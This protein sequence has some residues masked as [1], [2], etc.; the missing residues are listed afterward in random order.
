MP[1]PLVWAD[2]RSTSP[3]QRRA[4]AGLITRDLSRTPA[5]LIGR[6][7]SRSMRPWRNSQLCAAFADRS[8]APRVLSVAMLERTAIAAMLCTGCVVFP[9]SLEPPPN[10][11]TTVVLLTGTLDVPLD[12]VARHPWF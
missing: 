11:L 4:R 6:P 2:Q 1:T 7:G 10:D 5:H 8:A 9:H 12:D 3:D